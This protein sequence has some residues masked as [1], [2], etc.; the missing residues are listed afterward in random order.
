MVTKCIAISED[1][2]IEYCMLTKEYLEGALDVMRKSFFMFE[3]VSVAVELPLSPLAVTELNELVL[4][5]IS[6]GV[7][8]VAVDKIT[9]NVAGISLNKMNLPNA[10]HDMYLPNYRDSC[11]TPQAKALIQFMIDIDSECNLFESINVDCVIEI[12]FLAVMPD[13]LGKGI[14]K[15]LNQLSV[16]IIR[17]LY[18]GENIKI[19]LTGD[20][21]PLGPRPLAVSAYYTSVVTQKIGEK[22]GFQ[23]A[24]SISYD[25]WSYNGK[26]FSET[27]GPETPN[28]TVDYFLF[29]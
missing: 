21:L 20:S 1:G 29:K 23:R 19:S 18:D 3:T 2:A 9:R 4:R 5:T 14:A 15:Q 24:A 7:S 8:I 11:K 26:L 6:D 22:Q 17:K 27:I 10:E 25:K 28:A 12:M 16:D 13:Y